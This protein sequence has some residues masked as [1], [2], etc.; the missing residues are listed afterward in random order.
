MSRR[1]R[2]GR[3][4]LDRNNVLLRPMQIVLIRGET[5]F[6]GHQGLVMDAASDLEPEDGPIAVFLDREVDNH[7]FNGP[8]R[9]RF[10]MWKGPVPTPE[11]YKKSERVICFEP[12][13]LI[14]ESEWSLETLAVRLYG[15]DMWHSLMQMKYR[16]IP[17]IWD[18]S[19]ADCK[20]G[21]MATERTLVNFVGSI[22]EIY[23][24]AECHKSRH[25]M[26]TESMQLRGAP[27]IG[28]EPDP[29]SHFGLQYRM[30]KIDEE[31]TARQKTA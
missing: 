27:A 14:V 28:P 12:R 19:F 1:R 11:S 29:G 18:C 30:R 17:S 24:C 20:S 15:K 13:Q 5:S 21:L 6:D 26:C 3:P 8:M 16:L 4:P 25:G 31:I 10:G 7:H 2:A 9:F 22:Y 23:S